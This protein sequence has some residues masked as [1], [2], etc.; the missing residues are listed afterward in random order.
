MTWTHA[1]A[2][3]IKRLTSRLFVGTSVR[4][5]ALR[6]VVSIVLMS[7]SVSESPTSALPF[8]PTHMRPKVRCWRMVYSQQLQATHC[9][10][11]P[12]HTGRWFSP[13]GDRWW[14]VWACRDH[15]EELTGVRQFGMSSS[16][17]TH[18]ML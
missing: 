3:Q 17:G 4:K 2:L 18:T 12:T 16:P 1:N 14:R 8:D 13:R 9:R 10:E 6:D 5:Q 7:V 15:L 11:K